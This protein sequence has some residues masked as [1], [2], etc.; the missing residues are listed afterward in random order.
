MSFY[1]PFPPLSIKM[2]DK[3]GLD[4]VLRRTT[5]AVRDRGTGKALSAPTVINQPI[6]VAESTVEIETKEGLTRNA[7]AF[8]VWNECKTGDVIVFAGKSYKVTKV[9]Q[10][11]AAGVPLYWTAIVESGA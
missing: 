5:A 10:E 3:F 4:A 6:K 2:R 1:A 7:S 8:T 11:S 9:E